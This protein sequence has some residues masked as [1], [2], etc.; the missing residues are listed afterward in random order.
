MAEQIAWFDGQ[1]DER[2]SILNL[3]A[4]MEASV[5]HLHKA[6]VLAR[7]AFDA[8]MRAGRPEAAANVEVSHALFEAEL[9]GDDAARAR[10]SNATALA[11]DQIGVKSRAALAYAMVGDGARARSFAAELTTRF[12]RS[13]LFRSYWL[14][15]IQ[16][17]LLVRTNPLRSIEILQVAVPYELS[18]FSPCMYPTRIRGEAYLAVRQ[19]RAAAA[20]FQKVVDHRGLVAPCATASLA[21][22]GLARAYALAAQSGQGAEVAQDLS[23]ARAAYQDFLTSWKDADADHP[24]LQAARAEAARLR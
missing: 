9:G 21:R 11:P 14:P 10:A 13:T 22:L 12:P 4:G 7:Q 23:K 5:G 15:A 1:P 2:V 16:A 8:A 17:Q 3:A 19:G 24:I 18:G 20:E 6:R